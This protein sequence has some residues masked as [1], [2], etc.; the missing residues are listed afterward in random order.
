MGCSN[1]VRSESHLSAS[2]SRAVGAWSTRIDD[3]L[4]CPGQAARY[5]DG[6][7]GRLQHPNAHTMVAGGNCVDHRSRKD[8]RRE[9][10]FSMTLVAVVRTL[11]VCGALLCVASLAA[12]GPQVTG[13]QTID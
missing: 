6:H 11:G 4:V 3:R 9:G 12:Q 7:H 8:Q 13:L 2:N 5:V 1:E 10:G